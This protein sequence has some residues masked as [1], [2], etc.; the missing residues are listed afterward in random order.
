MQPQIYNIENVCVWEAPK[1]D[2]LRLTFNLD[3]PMDHL[4]NFLTR[5]ICVEKGLGNT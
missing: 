3:Q 1:I 5:G 2:L 4:E